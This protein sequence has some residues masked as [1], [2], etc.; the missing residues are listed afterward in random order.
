MHKMGLARLSV[1]AAISFI[2]LGLILPGTYAEECFNLGYGGSTPIYCCGINSERFNVPQ[3]FNESMDGDPDG[4]IA[5]CTSHRHC[6]DNAICYLPGTIMDVDGDGDTDYCK[7][8]GAMYNHGSIWVDCIHDS[9]CFP[10]KFCYDYDC[11]QKP[12]HI[13]NLGATGF[14]QTNPEYTSLRTVYLTLYFPPEANKCRYTNYHNASMPPDNYAGWTSWEPCVSNRMWELTEETGVKTVFYQINFS[15]GS[16]QWQYQEDPDA[17]ACSAGWEAMTPCSQIYD[18]NWNTFGRDS[19]NLGS[20]F[21]NITYTKNFWA[22]QLMRWQVKDIWGTRNLTLPLTCSNRNNILFQIESYLDDVMPNS[23]VRYYCYNGTA[24]ETLYTVMNSTGVAPVIYEEALWWAPSI[25]YDTIYYDYT[26]AG[27]DTTPPTAPYLVFENFTNT[28][29]I[30]YSWPNASDPESEILGIPLIYNVTL[31]NRTGA[32][33]NISTTAT[34]HTFTVPLVHNTTWF[35]NVTVFNSAWLTSNASSFP[36]GTTIDTE[37]P[38]ILRLNA[39][40]LNNSQYQVLPESTWVYANEINFSWLGNDTLSRE[41]VA[42]SYLL[43]AAGT[44]PDDIPEGAIGQFAQE[45]HKTY[46]VQSG[47]YFFKVK[48]KDKAGNWGASLSK[49]V[50]LDNTPPTKPV[51]LSETRHLNEITYLWSEAADPESGIAAYMINL[52]NSTGHL[53]DSAI[54]LSSEFSHTF[55]ITDSDTY[56]VNA[57]AVNGVGLW[58]WSDDEELDIDTDPPVIYATPIDHAWT[59]NPIL[60]AWTN[61]PAACFYHLQ[62]DPPATVFIYTNTTYHETKIRNLNEDYYHYNITCTDPFG[63]S[64]SVVI[65]FQVVSEVSS[66][67]M[68]GLPEIQAYENTVADYY[69]RINGFVG[70]L[71]VETPTAGITAQ[72]MKLYI[73]DIEHEFLLFDRGDGHYNLSFDA[74]LP[75]SYEADVLIDDEHRYEFIIT[76]QKISLDV[77]YEDPVIEPGVRTGNINYIITEDYSFGLASDTAQQVNKL[78][79]GYMDIS[80]VKLDKTSFIFMTKPD[81]KLR[82]REKRLTDG[83]IFEMVNPSFGYPADNR[84]FVNYVLQFDNVVLSSDTEKLE[85]GQHNF[86]L[87]SASIKGINY[88]SFSKTGAQRERIILTG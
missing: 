51:I 25:Y 28:N 57:G 34:T 9:Q 55:A 14:D 44:E 88:I 27:L 16:N 22:S 59:E 41:V 60:R 1:L 18:G 52:T 19:P 54:K 79:S 10:G 75:G 49:E 81:L 80:N 4:L 12:I 30:T 86:V 77:A 68:H 6:A 5:C 71:F 58:S 42:Y 73:D 13:S 2:I 38:F 83:K 3:R 63:I 11:V 37:P 31:Y 61:K 17:T 76:V 64:G 66:L 35:I 23:F 29:Q 45:T 56:N 65:D 24:F 32:K 87:R 67:V 8:A 48:A 36:H 84:Q 85:K 33:Q 82:D 40:F 72:R 50:W 20:S 7:L 15:T 74:P 46:Q 53:A 69:L 26:G 39:T 70:M 78:G 21:I 47:K 62:H 43:S